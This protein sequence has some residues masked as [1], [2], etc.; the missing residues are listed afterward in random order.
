MC[1]LKP[2]R[3]KQTSGWVSE[4]KTFSSWLMFPLLA[5]AITSTAKRPPEAKSSSSHN[6]PRCDN[7]HLYCASGFS[8]GA[9]RRGA[10]VGMFLPP[11]WFVSRE[12]RTLLPR[13][14]HHFY[15]GA[16]TATV[17]S[18]YSNLVSH[19]AWR[20]IPCLQLWHLVHSFIILLSARVT[21][22]QSRD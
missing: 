12:V 5:S 7:A 4:G 2:A 14:L 16:L 3:P 19:W 6:D 17:L 10:A 22:N 20:L 13:F 11:W 15:S 8:S 21:P 18:V 1:S 9:E